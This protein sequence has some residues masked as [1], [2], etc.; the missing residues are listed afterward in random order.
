MH[1]VPIHG[2]TLTLTRLRS[3]S[4]GTGAPQGRFFA[5]GLARA[6]D[7]RTSSSLGIGEP[8]L[9]RDQDGIG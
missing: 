4:S 6:G 1:E 3:S 5:L 9:P 8:V 2:S 7:S